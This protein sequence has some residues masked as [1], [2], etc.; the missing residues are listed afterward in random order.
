MTYP[1]PLITLLIL[2]ALTSTPSLAQ[3]SG[4]AQNTNTISD[5]SSRSNINTS[6]VRPRR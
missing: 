2:A 4:G 6:A 1:K 5:A 3:E